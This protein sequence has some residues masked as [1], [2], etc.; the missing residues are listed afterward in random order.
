LELLEWWT[1]TQKFFPSTKSISLKEIMFKFQAKTKV[2]FG[3]EIVRQI[4]IE[5][6]ALKA[7]DVVIVTDKGI[8]RAGLLDHVTRLLEAANVGVTVF[9]EVEPNPTGATIMKGAQCVKDVQ[10]PAVIGLGGGSPMDAAKSVAVMAMNDGTVEQYC[11]GADPWPV[12]PLPVLAIPTTAGTG[13]EVSSAAM[14]N[15]PDQGIKAAMFGPSILPK[16]ALVDPLL[17]LGLPPRLTA[18]TGIDALCHAVEAYTCARANPI[19]DAIAERAIELV[20]NNLR[21]AFANGKN[22]EARGN[23]L[24]ASTMAILAAINSGGLGIIHSLAQTIGGYYN[25]PHGLTI[26]VCYPIGLEYNTIAMP[27]KYARVSQLMG[28]NTSGMTLIEAAK[29]AVTAHKELIA[30]LE[31]TDSLKSIGVR[32]DDIP[33]LAELA[34]LDGSTPVNPRTID[35]KG[36]EYLYDQAF[37]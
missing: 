27:E 36:F 18:L 24:L 23:M 37:D 1:I 21:Q 33:R 28:T 30:D 13:A 16:V 29:S 14:V 4:G 15:L 35:A 9:D 12:A 26:A 31:V 34:M 8:V 2:L 19:S 7:E 10:A 17:T 3:P 22:V 6:A 32:R 25:L 5:V 11:S 20:G